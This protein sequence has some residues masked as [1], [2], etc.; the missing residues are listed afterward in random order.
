MVATC[1]VGETLRL[2]EKGD[3]KEITFRDLFHLNV[4]HADRC[5]LGLV[6]YKNLRRDRGLEVVSFLVAFLPKS[7]GVTCP[8]IPVAE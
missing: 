4:L 2:G 1:P 7:H 3:Q 6:A 8:I 5:R